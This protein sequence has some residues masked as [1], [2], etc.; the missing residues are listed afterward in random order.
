VTARLIYASITSLDGYVADQHGS[1]D[2]S[3]PDDEVHSFVNELQRPIGT[4]LYGRRLYEVMLAW[5]TMATEGEPESLRQYADI[6]RAADKIVYSTTLDRATSARTRVERHFD[7][8]VVRQ[9]KER[10]ARDLLIGGPQLAAEAL[11]A[12]LVDEIHQLL[13]PVVVGGGKR[14]L[15]DDLSLRLELLDHRRFGNGVVYLRYDVLH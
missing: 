11:H 1:F 5:E 3:M 7:A 6:W 12:G 4:Y 10:A 13:S 9:L 2:W 14:F 15:P 8:D